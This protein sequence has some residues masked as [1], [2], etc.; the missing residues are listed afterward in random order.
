MD[1]IYKRRGGD[2]VLKDPYLREVDYKDP[3]IC[4]SC[5]A[6]YHNKRWQFNDSLEHEIRL[7]D[8]YEEKMC[9]ACRK[10]KDNYPMGLVFISG[11]FINQHKEEILS[12]VKSEE[13]RAVDKNP[14]ERIMEIEKENVNHYR[15]ETTTDTL[16]QRIGKIL[17]NSYK[18]EVEY[19]FS[20][21]Q[22]VL[23]VFW[24]RED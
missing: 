16:A 18:G 22:K 13:K 15:I 9:P 10:I 1:K 11:N 21:G 2:A 14:L 12:T 24:S 5:K 4:P 3:N 20:E 23:Q 7:E 17:H 8:D 19:K 6:L